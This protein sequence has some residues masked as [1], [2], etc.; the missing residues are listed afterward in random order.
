MTIYIFHVP[1]FVGTL[2][3]YLYVINLTGHNCDHILVIPL[4]DKYRVLL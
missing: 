4:L 3:I 1:S 2:I